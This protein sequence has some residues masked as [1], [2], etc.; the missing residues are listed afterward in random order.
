MITLELHKWWGRVAVKI[1][2]TETFIQVGQRKN[3]HGFY[4]RIKVWQH[5]YENEHQP[6]MVTFSRIIFEIF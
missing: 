4:S 3:K 6:D 5:L 1:K 2:G